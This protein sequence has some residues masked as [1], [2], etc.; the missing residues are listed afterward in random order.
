M[1]SIRKT[2]QL[3][4]PNIFGNETKYLKECIKSNYLT[5]GKHSE[6]FLNKIKNITNSKYPALVHNC[7]SGLYMC[8]KIAD[9]K[10]D[11][12]V[13]VPS[14]TF[15]ASINVVKYCSANPIFMDVDEYCNIDLKIKVIKVLISHQ[16]E[17]FRFSHAF[18][19]LQSYI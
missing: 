9:T 10:K 12:E 4:T 3:H 17:P 16:H 8:L 2:I 19:G 1:K 7:T 5:F 15:V 13:I 14:I 11:D 6:L 18:P